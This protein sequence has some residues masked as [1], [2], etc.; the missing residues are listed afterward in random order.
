LV[1]N[2][3]SKNIQANDVIK[4]SSNEIKND[5]A[6]VKNHYLEECININFM[7][8]KLLLTLKSLLNYYMTQLYNLLLVY[9]ITITILIK[10]ILSTFKL[11]W[12]KIF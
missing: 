12:H 4:K 3:T 8:L 10:V 7:N 11:A 9:N 1:Y 2:P 6:P 5:S